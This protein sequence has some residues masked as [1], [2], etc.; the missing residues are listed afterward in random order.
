LLGVLSPTNAAN[1]SDTEYYLRDVAAEFAIE[2]VASLPVVG[3]V[4]QQ[5]KP[6]WPWAWN[7][8]E[9]VVPA[10]EGEITPMVE[11]V[12]RLRVRGTAES[13]PRHM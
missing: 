3:A 9:A 2:V 1:L 13:L 12:Y 5:F 11:P 10:I 4:R 6:T 7:G 8:S